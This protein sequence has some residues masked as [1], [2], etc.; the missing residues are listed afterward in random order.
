MRSLNNQ[1]KVYA[2]PL[3]WL[4]VFTKQLTTVNISYILLYLMINKLQVK[5]SINIQPRY[6]SPTNLQMI[7]QE[8]RNVNLVKS[9]VIP[10]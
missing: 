2:P 8:K 4:V 9:P 10:F 3:D 5:K 6:I 7:A 1:Y